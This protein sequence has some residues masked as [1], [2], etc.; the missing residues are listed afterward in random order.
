[1]AQGASGR[2]GPGWL[3]EAVFYQVY[4]QSFKDS[5]GDGIGDLPGLTEKL[6]YI[7]ELGAN[8]LW[9]NPCFESAF[10]DAGYD[11]SDFMR[12][13][14]RYGNNEDMRALLREAHGRGMRVLLDLVAGHTSV[15]H[16]WFRRS[17]R[18]EPGYAGRYI[19]ADDVWERFEGV[20]GV[21]GSINGFC[22][23]GSCAT[24]F[25]STQPALNYGFAKP[26][27]PWQSA[28]DSPEATASREALKD[29]MRF[30]LEMG[31]DGFRVDMA[32]SIVKADRGKRETIR[33]WRGIR[34]FLDREFPEAAIISEWGD[35]RQALRA[36]FHMD[37]LLHFG[38]GRYNDLFREK[39]FF[40]KAGGGDASRFAEGYAAMSAG[41]KGLICIPSSNH[42][43][44]RIA[45]LL[46]TEDLKLAFAFLLS[47]PGAPFIYYGDEIGMRFLEG[48]PSVEGGFERTGSRSPMQWDGSLNAGFSSGRPQDLYI[49]IDA[50]PARPTVKAQM[51]DPG[52]LWREVQK[53]IAV[54]RRHEALQNDSPIEFLY[55]RPGECPLVYRRGSGAGAITVA[56]NPSGRPVSFE[57]GGL[58]AEGARV[59]CFTGRSPA[60]EGGAVT[61]P[62]C[63]GAFL[64]RR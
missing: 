12:I 31:C 1:M 52:S 39:P 20:G 34:A 19:W 41:G 42:D 43:M 5:D 58:G 32:H 59:I 9:I 49:P 53:L 35:T 57:A 63:S 51:D 45:R 25:Y 11:V 47:M 7:E 37:F 64:S 10:H 38:A 21:L 61:L 23:R 33:F 8:A 6:G 15:E 44:P 14:P 36:G 60:F 28:V 29:V 27:K 24:N 54:R 4:P 56:L 46:D 3:K 62:P 40:C 17:M 55:A 50:D 18:G 22:E 48:L 16:D 26:T 2:A 13:A 30:W